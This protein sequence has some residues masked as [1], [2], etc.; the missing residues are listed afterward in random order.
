MA[1][2][3]NYGNFFNR[4]ALNGNNKR[5]STGQTDEATKAPAA[6]PVDVAP[7][8][9]IKLTDG[10]W[11]TLC[12]IDISRSATNVENKEIAGTTNE[13]LASLGHNY[14]VSAA[15]VASVTEGLNK[16]VLP[17]L[18]TAANE[19]TAARAGKS[20]EEFDKALGLA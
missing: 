15:Q 2:T 6:K 1:I 12:G 13:V 9:A 5:V 3:G 7:Q 14:K 8:D 16:T 19:A 17:S 20:L 11:K 4:L 18:N 10:D